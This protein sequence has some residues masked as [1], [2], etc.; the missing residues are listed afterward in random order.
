M[1]GKDFLKAEPLYLKIIYIIGL[2]FFLLHFNELVSEK[3]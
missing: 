1:P 2:T 3:E